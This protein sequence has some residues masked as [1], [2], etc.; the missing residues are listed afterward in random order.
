MYGGQMSFSG[1]GGQLGQQQQLAARAA[2]LGQGQLGMMQGQGN[3]VSAAHYGLQSQMMSQV[4]LGFE[5][6]QN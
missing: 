2:M 3:A 5:I 4:K 1:G 6:R